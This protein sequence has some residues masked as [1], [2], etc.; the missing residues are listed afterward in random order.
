LQAK[1]GDT[2]YFVPTAIGDGGR[3]GRYALEQLDPD[4]GTYLVSN[5]RF[6]TSQHK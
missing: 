1:A 6:G 4:E 2:Y 3:G 5:A